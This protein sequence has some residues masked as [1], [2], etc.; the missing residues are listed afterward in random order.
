MLLMGKLGIDVIACPVIRRNRCTILLADQLS[1]SFGRPLAQ[2]VE[3]L[4]MINLC[5]RCGE[6]GEIGS[7]FSGAAISEAFPDK[8]DMP[9]STIR[10]SPLRGV[11][12]EFNSVP[13]KPRFQLIWNSPPSAEYGRPRAEMRFHRKMRPEYFAS[14][15]LDAD[16]IVNALLGRG[17]AAGKDRKSG[18]CGSVWKFIV[19]S[20]HLQAL[21]AVCGSSVR[22]S[23]PSSAECVPGVNGMGRDLCPQS[24]KRVRCSL[25]HTAAGARR[26]PL[27]PAPWR[28]ACFPTWGVCDMAHDHIGHLGGHRHKVVGHRARSEAGAYLVIVDFPS[29]SA[30][31]NPAQCRP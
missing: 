26:C 28:P 29:Y 16:M 6:G 7:R 24:G 22:Q 3:N 8:C 9:T 18:G 14:G 25:H 31:P 27:R 21:P 17:P 2:L 1:R 20:S 23:V 11:S 5:G 19:A 4:S 10:P 30:P 13:H 12:G 15:W